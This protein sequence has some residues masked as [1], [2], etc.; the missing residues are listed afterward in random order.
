MRFLLHIFVVFFHKQ[1][2]YRLIITD[3]L[4]ARMDQVKMLSLSKQV[5]PESCITVLDLRNA[6]PVPDDV[7]HVERCVL[8]KCV[9]YN[10]IFTVGALQS[11]MD[12]QQT[13]KA[14]LEKCI[15]LNHFIVSSGSV[16]A[17]ACSGSVFHAD[18]L[19]YTKTPS[20]NLVCNQSSQKF[21][22]IDWRL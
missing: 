12:H 4:N 21:V 8:Y 22:D 7:H 9:Y 15:V 18:G 20:P 3:L 13:P 5:S 10:Q 19:A 6:A 11:R 17:H 1:T 14:K 16:T 2:T